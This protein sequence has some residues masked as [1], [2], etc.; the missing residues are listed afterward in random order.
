VGESLELWLGTLGTLTSINYRSGMKQLVDGEYLNIGMSL[1][2]FALIN[3]DAVVDRIK[4]HSSWAE[5]TRQT[6]AACYISFTGFLSR[7][8]QGMIKKAQPCREGNAKTFYRVREKVK[9]EAMT[10]VQWTDFLNSFTNPRDQL[11]AKLAIQGAKR[12]N[13]VLGLTTG[14]ICWENCQITFAQSKTKGV[15]R[16]TVI[17]YPSSVMKS[18]KEYLGER[19]G[20]VFI[21]RTGKKVPL[22]Q[23]ATTFAK[24][25]VKA[26]IPFKVTPHVLRASA[27]TYHK[28]QGTSNSD[29]MKITGHNSSPML[30]AYD[31]SSR[32]ENA[33]K[34][35]QLVQ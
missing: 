35:I 23:M 16:E 34:K 31:K 33:S 20:L 5:C 22:I 10:L 25:G 17:T 6:R 7:R 12:I 2:A 19:Q 18:L 29:L 27:I 8:S 30:D 21:T 14:Q 9:T 4:N 28:Q 26:G 3:H 1:Q 13:E 32:A 15:K 24:A 11:I